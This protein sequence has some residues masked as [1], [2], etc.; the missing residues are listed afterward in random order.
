[1]EVSREE[2][3]R[4]RLDERRVLTQHVGER[5]QEKQIG[6]GLKRREQPDDARIHPASEVPGE[7]AQCRSEEAGKEG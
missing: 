6:D 7:R 3:P 5:Q 1:M 4:V 2:R